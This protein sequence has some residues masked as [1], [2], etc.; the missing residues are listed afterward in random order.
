MAER[1]SS[2]DEKKVYPDHDVKDYDFEVVPVYD[3]DGPIEF[4][5]KADLR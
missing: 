2:D 1:I 5:E 3:Q 4:A